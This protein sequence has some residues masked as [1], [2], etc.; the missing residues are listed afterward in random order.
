[1]SCVDDCNHNGDCVYGTCKCR[2]GYLGEDCA[3]HENDAPNIIGIPDN[4]LCDLSERPC[5]QT[6]VVGKHFVDGNLQCRL[7]PFKVF[8][9]N[10]IVKATA[11]SARARDLTRFSKCFAPCQELNGIVYTRGIVIIKAPRSVVTDAS[12]GNIRLDTR[13]LHD[14]DWLRFIKTLEHWCC[15]RIVGY[16]CPNLKQETKSSRR[17]YAGFHSRPNRRSN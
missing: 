3:I 1:M 11:I 9:D 15:S 4:G 13:R 8:S 6:A 17:R 5:E 14:L 16:M 10:S 2:T 12:T 7:V